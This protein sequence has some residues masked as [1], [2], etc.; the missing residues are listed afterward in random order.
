M[1]S[2]AVARTKIAITFGLGTQSKQTTGFA[3]AKKQY[4]FLTASALFNKIFAGCLTS[5]LLMFLL[6]GSYFQQWLLL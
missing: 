1:A 6:S 2:H 4:T 5:R 3:M